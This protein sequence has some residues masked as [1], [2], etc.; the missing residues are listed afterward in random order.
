MNASTIV[1]EPDPPAPRPP[2]RRPPLDAYGDPVVQAKQ[3]IAGNG[4]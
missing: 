1:L 4:W 2:V 3:V